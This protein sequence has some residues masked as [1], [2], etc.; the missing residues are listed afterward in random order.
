VLDD[1]RRRGMEVLPI[2]PFVAAYVKR[3]PEYTDL[4]RF[5]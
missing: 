1:V 4:L 5:Q 3:H 2:C